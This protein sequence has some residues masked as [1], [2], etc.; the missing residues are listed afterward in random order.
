MVR[1]GTTSSYTPCYG[2]KAG[3]AF[4]IACVSQ[5]TGDWSSSATKSTD[6]SNQSVRLAL[7][8]ASPVDANDRL[9]L[10]ADDDQ[11][12]LALVL[13][14]S[15]HTRTYSARCSPVS[16]ACLA[17]SSAGFPSNTMRPPSCPAPGPRSMIQSACAITAW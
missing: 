16:V 11:C 2:R 10:G 15:R 14:H 17:T 6:W 1:C 9:S 4:G 3:N 12:R 7:S 8:E 13:M 5:R